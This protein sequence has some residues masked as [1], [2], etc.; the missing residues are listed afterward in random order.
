MTKIIAFWAMGLLT[1]AFVIG[2]GTWLFFFVIAK[3][4]KHKII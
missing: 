2:G 1:I 3:L 4:K